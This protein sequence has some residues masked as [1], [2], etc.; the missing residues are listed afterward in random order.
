MMPG[1][2]DSD[3]PTSVPPPTAATSHPNDG[4]SIGFDDPLFAAPSVTRSAMRYLLGAEIARGGM[5]AVYV[6]KDTVLNR[7]IA[8][9]VLLEKQTAG[10]GSASTRRFQDEAQ[11]TGQL[12]H[13]GIPP[14][15]DIGV[16]HDGRPFLAMKL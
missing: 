12:Q 3:S 6:A 13:P 11:I 2:N 9:K 14:V 1:E 16:L 5:G 7:E 15:H 4:Y 8:V 10:S